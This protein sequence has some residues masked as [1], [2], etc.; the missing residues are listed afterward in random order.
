MK[1]TIDEKEFLHDLVNS[2]GWSVLLK[3]I[4]Q[5]ATNI[6]SA[7]LRYNLSDGTDKLVHAK[8]RSEGSRQLQLAIMNIKQEFKQA[9]KGL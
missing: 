4:E 7:V 5:M 9:D 6:D 2:S 8:A 1:L 3:R